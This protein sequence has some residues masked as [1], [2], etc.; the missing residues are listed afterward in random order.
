MKNMNQ[1]RIAISIIRCAQDRVS[2]IIK[3][4]KVEKKFVFV[5]TPE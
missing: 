1:V 5:L 3:L 2:L 4:G